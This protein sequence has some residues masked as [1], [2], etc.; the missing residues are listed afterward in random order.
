MIA[1]K[2]KG[3]VVVGDRVVC[4]PVVARYV[5]KDPLFV[6][7]TFVQAG[8]DAVWEISRDLLLEAIKNPTLTAGEG[9]VQARVGPM[10]AYLYLT[11]TSTTGESIV[12]LPLKDVEEF[13]ASTTQQVPVGEEKINVDRAI[14]KILEGV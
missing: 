3:R 5:K 7:M 10:L 12:S 8:G 14:R 1:A 4:I 6:R 13:V 11:L 9:E 2:W